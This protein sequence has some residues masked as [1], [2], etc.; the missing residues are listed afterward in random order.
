MELPKGFG[1]GELFGTVHYKDFLIIGDFSN[2]IN[3]AKHEKSRF[4]FFGKS[5]DEL[6]QKIDKRTEKKAK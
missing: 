3:I 5:I 2:N 6:K 4:V 1:K